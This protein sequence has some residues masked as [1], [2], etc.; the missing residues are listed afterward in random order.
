[1]SWLSVTGDRL[2]LA[3]RQPYAAL[4]TDSIEKDLRALAR[5]LGLKPVF[6]ALPQSG[7][8]GEAGPNGDLLSAAK[9]GPL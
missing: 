5:M 9:A 4:F 7:D 3:V 2:Q 8:D 1:V 6:T